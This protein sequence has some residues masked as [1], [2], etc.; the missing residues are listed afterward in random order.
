MMYD[1]ITHAGNEIVTETK[2]TELIM[3]GD[4]V[5]G[6]KAVGDD[7]TQWTVHAKAVSS[8]H[9]RPGCRTGSWWSSTPPTMQ[10]ST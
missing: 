6:V 10:A 3:D 9:G 8:V 5:A 4:A 1:R 7:G 2:V